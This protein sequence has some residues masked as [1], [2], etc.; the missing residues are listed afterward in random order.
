M[1]IYK[2][3]KLNN[4]HFLILGIWRVLLIK[5]KFEIKLVK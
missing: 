5:V 3:K 1:N 2:L 4:F